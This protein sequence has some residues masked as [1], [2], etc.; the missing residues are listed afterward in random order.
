V[1]RAPLLVLAVLGLLCA[2]P[3]AGDIGGCGT[4]ASS[5]DTGVFTSARKDLDCR[6][7]AECEIPTARCKSACDRSRPP[8]TQIPKTCQPLLHDGEVCLRKLEAVSCD[9]FATYV[10]DV[11]PSTPSECEFCKLPSASPAPSFAVDAAI[12]DGAP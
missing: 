9:A 11:A 6:R 1:R 10:S 5:L 3:T 4:E 2:A 8:E 12:T 7:C